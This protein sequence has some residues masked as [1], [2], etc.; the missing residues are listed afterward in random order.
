MSMIGQLWWGT[1]MLCICIVFHT[2]VVYFTLTWVKSLLHVFRNHHWSTVFVP[3]I[4]LSCFSLIAGHTL[5]VW[6]WATVLLQLGTLPNL[7]LA[8]YYALVTYTTVGYGDVTLAQDYAIFGAFA[9][10]VGLFAF[11]ISSA[12]LV[13]IVMRF[14]PRV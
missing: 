14:L 7:E 3:V 9:S 2:A 11:G 5:Q 10:V 8:L 12:F 1:V 4:A 13:G 6:L